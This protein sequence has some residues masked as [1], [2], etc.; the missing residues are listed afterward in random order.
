M[1]FI[2]DF[3]T[4]NRIKS[5]NNDIIT[6]DRK[7]VESLAPTVFYPQR[8]GKY[9]QANG[10]IIQCLTVGD[11]SPVNPNRKG[12]PA[13]ENLRLIDDLLKLPISDDTCISIAQISIS[14]PPQDE[15]KE[16]EKARRDNLILA[17]MQEA[18][19]EGFV[20]THDQ[21]NDFI[22]EDISSYNRAVFEGRLRMFEFS[23]LI[24]V[25]GL[26]VGAVDDTM[27]LIIALLDG[28]RVIH[29]IPEFGEVDTYL[30]MMLTPFIKQRLLS[31]TS[32]EMVALTS[33]LRNPNPRLA[34]SGRLLGIN[35][36]TNNPLFLNFKNGSL[37]NGHCLVIG[38]SGSGKSTLLLNDD[39]KALQ[40]GDEA[41]HVVPKA[42][43]DTSHLRVCEAMSGQLISVGPDFPNMMQVFFD[44]ERM[45]NSISS[46]QT[47]YS[48]HVMNLT[49]EI[50]LLIGD[51]FSDPQKNWVYTS[52]VELYEQSH[53]IDSEG[54]VINIDKWENGMFWPTLEDLRD[55]WYTWLND[56]E[57]KTPAIQ[58]I[59]AALYNN[60]AMIT[61]KGPLGFLI[62]HNSLKLRNRF[63]MVD[64][65]ALIDTPNVQDALIMMITSILNVKLLCRKGGEKK[66]IFITIDEG[67]NLVKIPR[68]KKNIERMF[69]EFRSAGGH[70]K[71][72]FQDIFGVEKDMLNM[73]K[74]NTDYIILLSNLGAY[75]IKP[76]VKEFN[77]T[78]ND[79]RRLKARG[80]GR[81]LFIMGDTHINYMNALDEFPTEVILGKKDLNITVKQNT[82]PVINL[83]PMV[84][85]LKKDHGIFL[86]DWLV[87]VPDRQL[88]KI[89]GYDVEQFTHPFSG[90]QKT[91]Y[92][93]I[94]LEKENGHIKNQTK[95]HYFTVC[96]LAGELCLMGAKVYLDHYGTDKEAD[97][98]AVF[99]DGRVIAFEY[100]VEGSHTRE[101]LI[102]KRKRLLHKKQASDSVISD[103]IFFSKQDY[104]P[105]LREALGVDFAVQ[106]GSKL[107]A[108]ID[109]ILESQP[110]Q[111][112]EK[113]SVIIPQL[114]KQ[115]A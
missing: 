83:Y 17:A 61:R 36:D 78:R 12:I 70:V 56:G 24:A 27:S 101:E 29:E 89:P 57:H 59:I 100:E 98:L 66:H 5:M 34:N 91:V 75:N 45:D 58:S 40:D 104:Y 43:E 95:D 108:K 88:V 77:L 9:L 53:V 55:L 72:V 52:I 109:H 20:K 19:D 13:N 47:A 97:I 38:K 86:K 33:P 62:N 41:F 92:V 73:M 106:R 2:N 23:L 96:L 113:C 11:P 25:K 18:N 67:A 80:H 99:P 42:D 32:G 65:S 30:S 10:L 68:M 14:L 85:W 21:I 63:T 31:T 50:G 16:L 74:T 115:S 93:R 8:N 71:I 1:S 6:T 46:Y 69:R 81:G 103:L 22:G 7:L 102:K 49:E 37:I 76:L 82:E 44:P 94:G 15:N 28:K 60:T 54:N 110:L 111:I 35:E 3:K 4:W 107:K 48:K 51:S 90:G 114:V 105:K 87:G 84:E 64:I 26:S 39:L 112:T 79:I